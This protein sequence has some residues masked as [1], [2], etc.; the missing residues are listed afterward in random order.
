MGVR[1]QEGKAMGNTSTL[2]SGAGSYSLCFEEPWA[3]L[4]RS[5]SPRDSPRDREAQQTEPQDFHP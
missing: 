1:I 5:E 2:V 4:G 3:S